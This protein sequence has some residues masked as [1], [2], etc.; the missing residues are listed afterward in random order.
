MRLDRL[1][2]IMGRGRNP[3]VTD[4]R[5]LLELLL[6]RD[7][8]VFVA[9]LADQVPLTQE[10]V[11]QLMTDLESRGLVEQNMVSNRNLY[12]LSDAGLDLLAEDLRDALD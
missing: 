9:E 2:R 11:R 7:R 6:A 4:S 5:L 3:S 1:S 8:A 10:R 12:R